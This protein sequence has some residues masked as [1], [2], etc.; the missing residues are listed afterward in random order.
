MMDGARSRDDFFVSLIE[1]PEGW[2][3]LQLAIA[4]KSNRPWE[5]LWN[6]AHPEAV[7]RAW[8]EN[9]FDL[10]S[11][12]RQKIRAMI[13]ECNQTFIL[14]MSPEEYAAQLWGCGAGEKIVDA[15]VTWMSGVTGEGVSPST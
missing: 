9:D 1:T 15:L 11:G 13:I 12:W 5:D 3:H 10:F 8:A 2:L 14:K 7:G 6:E 4:C